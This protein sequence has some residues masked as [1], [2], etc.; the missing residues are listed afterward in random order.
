V[1]DPEKEFL[2][3][4]REAFAFEASEQLK[5]IS[6]HLL[7]LERQD[8]E[9]TRKELIEIIF[10]Q[11]HNL[12]GSARAVNMSNIESLCHT[13]ESQLAEMKKGKVPLVDNYL[14]VLLKCVD[15]LEK[16][17]AEEDVASEPLQAALVGAKQS[18][19]S[20]F[21]APASAGSDQVPLANEAPDFGQAAS[22]ATADRV[23]TMDSVRLSAAKLDEL[24]IQAEEMLSV[25][26]ATAQHASEIAALT[27]EA[28]LWK[29]EWHNFD[30][31]L[32]AL[33]AISTREPDQIDM[34]QALTQ[35]NKVIGFADWNHTKINNWLAKLLQ[36]R[37]LFEA[38]TYNVTVGVDSFL[39]STKKLL[40]M[41][42]S[43]LL[44]GFPRLVREMSR[45]LGKEVEFTMVG[46][47]I[48]FDRRILTTMRDPLLHLIRNSID[49]GIEAPDVRERAGKPAKASLLLSVN[50]DETGQVEISIADDGAGID[51]EKVTG[52]AIKTGAISEA[53]AQAMP[54]DEKVNLI[55]QSAVSTSAI[56]TDISGR[57]LGL[58][59]VKENVDNLG[60]RL[61][62]ETTLASGTKFKI[63]LPVAVATFQG[64]LLDVGGEM[65]AVPKTNL[66]RVLRLYENQIRKIE[67]KDAFEFGGAL[68]SVIKLASLLDIEN[69]KSE[70]SSL[71]FLL[72]AVVRAGG[73]ILGLVID[74]VLEEQE[75]MVKKFGK[76]LNRVRNIAGITILRTGKV[77]PVLN[78]SDLIKS[79]RRQSAKN[80]SGQLLAPPVK[81]RI[82]VVDD[83]LTSRM[84][85]KNIM[86]AAGYEVKTANDGV[87]AF[88]ELNAEPFDLALVDVEMPRL[89]GLELTKRIRQH[90]QLADLPVVLLTTLAS[91]EHRERGVQAGANAYFTK[92]SFDQ[93][94]LLEVIKRL[95]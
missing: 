20:F 88:A 5:V 83:T 91:R 9:K 61:L 51:I 37:K 45:D 22:V 6:S 76:P 12:K 26:R 38:D 70:P 27:D 59:I 84:L 15:L 34:T 85:I 78:V 24:L 81:K 87:E 33:R 86:E 74:D 49:H 75:V 39:E 29:K 40:M 36:Q 79:A 52:A 58:A 43:A 56:I 62:V 77:V 10:R 50:Q 94:N 66:L 11:A 47:E 17:L 7:N 41:P 13:L 14:D 18:L 28:V 48:E 23:A 55:F 31:N 57:G 16:L 1:S 60:G 92:G 65:V 69:T 46:T 42:C 4:L 90:K 67:D 68:R 64:V 80:A 63:L 21:V 32:R 95:I 93:T 8:D 72:V 71:P 19:D 53:E 30:S 3:Q 25:K 82:L 73:D 44:E 35:I 54:N 2:K 89:D